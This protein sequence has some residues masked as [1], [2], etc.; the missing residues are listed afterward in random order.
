MMKASSFSQTPRPSHRDPCRRRSRALPLLAIRLTATPPLSL[1]TTPTH[2]KHPLRSLLDPNALLDVLRSSISN[3]VS[4]PQSSSNSS[5]NRDKSHSVTL[6]TDNQKTC[7]Q[8]QRHPSS[9]SSS[10]LLL[11]KKLLLTRQPLSA[12][13]CP[14]SYSQTQ[15]NAARPHQLKFSKT[16]LKR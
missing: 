7:H 14:R 6:L 16:S 15:C 4:N 3:Q 10:K 5:S 2:S 11:L 9:S 12:T 8:K 1:L 13:R